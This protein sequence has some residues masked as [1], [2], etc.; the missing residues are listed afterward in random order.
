MKVELLTDIKYH[1]KFIKAGVVIDVDLPRKEI[2]E[3]IQSGAIKKAEAL[4]VVTVV[5]QPKLEEV[6]VKEEEVTN[7]K[8]GN[9]NVESASVKAKAGRPKTVS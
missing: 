4:P 9:I 3:L 6:V 2:N 5:K 8:T 7:N 1:N